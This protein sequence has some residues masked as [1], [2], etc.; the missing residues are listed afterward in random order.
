[1]KMMQAKQME[2]EALKEIMPEPVMNRISSLEKELIDFGKEYFM[3][4]VC[5]DKKES[6]S[7]QPESKS[8]TRKVTIE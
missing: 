6:M 8:K 3:T 1:M 4:V 2:Y 7:A 5:T